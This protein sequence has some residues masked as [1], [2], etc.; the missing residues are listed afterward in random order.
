[1]EAA[2]SIKTGTIALILENRIHPELA[3]TLRIF[4]EPVR[5]SIPRK[6][7]SGFGPLTIPNS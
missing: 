3:K 6:K 4:I 2:P 5:A 1:M 7:T